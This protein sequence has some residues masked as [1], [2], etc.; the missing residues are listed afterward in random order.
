MYVRRCVVCKEYGEP[1]TYSVERELWVLV[2]RGC[3]HEVTTF[4][5]NYRLTDNGG[6]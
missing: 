3:Y 2:D 4:A 1:H 5:D 6:F